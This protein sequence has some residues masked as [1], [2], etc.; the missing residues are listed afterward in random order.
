MMSC[1]NPA[2]W[3][4]ATASTEETPSVLIVDDDQIA[5][6]ELAEVLDFEGYQCA[7]ASTQEQAVAIVSTF[8]TISIIITDF[9]LRGSGT[10]A[11]NGLTLIEK[12]QETFPTRA[13]DFIVVSGDPD[14][15]ADCALSGEGRFLSKPIAPES[16]CSMVNDVSTPVQTSDPDPE[17]DDS[18]SSLHRMVQIQADTIA[19]LTEALSANRANTGNVKSRL[20]RLMS[21]AVI[22]KRRNE[23]GGNG[24]TDELLNYIVGQSGAVQ[25]L[26]SD[27]AKDAN[28]SATAKADVAKLEED[29]S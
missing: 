26:L 23:D 15:L 22:A 20:D 25:K 1:S 16:I 18:I 6:S 12:V 11:G 5:A 28:R 7:T 19:S 14:I 3:P 27:D 10:V 17:A 29:Q 2:L 24:A 9:Y 13:F 21:A 8:Q 4:D